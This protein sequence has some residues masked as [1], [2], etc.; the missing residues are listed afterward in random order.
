[1][2]GSR[3]AL[4]D[5]LHDALVAFAERAGLGEEGVRYVTGKVADH[6]AGHFDAAKLEGPRRIRGRLLD[7]VD[8]L[9]SFKERQQVGGRYSGKA[10][11][12]N[13]FQR[14]REA[15][16]RL[17]ASGESITRASLAR[18]AAVSVQ[19]ATARW[20]VVMPIEKRKRKTVQISV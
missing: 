6:L 13:V 7:V 16:Q 10:K 12:A 5:E 11:A 17:V 20:S 9:K 18:A 1:M 19:T 4:A 8:G 2:R 3:A 14:L 15:H